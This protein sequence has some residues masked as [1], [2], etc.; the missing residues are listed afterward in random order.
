MKTRT[1]SRA[2]RCLALGLTLG[3]YGC[4]SSPGTSSENPAPSTMMPSGSLPNGMLPSNEVPASAG[5]G[6]IGNQGP[7]AGSG[8]QPVEMNPN[9][10][11]MGEP[12]PSCQGTDCAM[13]PGEPPM[14]NEG[15]AGSGPIV[16]DDGSLCGDPS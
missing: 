3:G 4:S 1:G 9:P 16:S 11:Q 14:G 13:M 10:Q 7:V 6:A 15:A 2:A 12:T 5:S 8:S